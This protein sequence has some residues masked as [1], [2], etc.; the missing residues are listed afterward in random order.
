MA[1]FGFLRLEFVSNHSDGERR[2]TPISHA[3]ALVPLASEVIAYASCRFP[4]LKEADEDRDILGAGPGQSVPRFLDVR[5]AFAA[6]NPLRTALPRGK[7]VG[8]WRGAP[9]SNPRPSV[10][11]TTALP[12]S[13][14]GAPLGGRLVFVRGAACDPP[15]IVF[16][17]TQT[18]GSAKDNFFAILQR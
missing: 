8:A 1:G 9:D 11:K 3:R 6:A 14:A 13:Y 5:A 2:R 18:G 7:F 17:Y 15:T 12:L 4:G 10:Y 16:A